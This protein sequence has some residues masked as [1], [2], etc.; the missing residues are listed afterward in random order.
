LNLYGFANGDPVNFSDPFGLCPEEDR[1]KDGRCP[2]GLT[3]DEWKAVENASKELYK[4]VAAALLQLLKAGK[5]H[6]MEYADATFLGWGDPFTSDVTIN[7][8]TWI[9]NPFQWGSADFAHL[10]GHELRHTGQL[11]GLSDQMKRE[12]VRTDLAG[13]QRDADLFGCESLVPTALKQLQI[14]ATK[15]GRGR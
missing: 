15:C 8:A 10:L 13:M 5:I 1:D 4:D 11:N 6:S 12:I 9:G 3:V 2:G 14:R 7:T